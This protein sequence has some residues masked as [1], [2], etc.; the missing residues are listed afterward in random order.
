M[1][2]PSIAILIVDAHDTVR[3]IV[4]N[5][6]K[7]LG[8]SNLHEAADE[9]SALVQLQQADIR[10]V[11]ADSLPFL[12]TVRAHSSAHSVITIL[13]TAEHHPD[14]LASVKEAGIAYLAKPFNPDSLKAKIAAVLVEA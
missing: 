13:A 3:H 4:R 2:D 6:L 14:F 5:Q 10:L 12:K 9:A 7:Q 8:F 11:I 1:V